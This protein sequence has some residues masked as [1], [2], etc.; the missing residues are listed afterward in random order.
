MEAGMKAVLVS[1]LATLCVGLVILFGFDALGWMR[2]SFGSSDSAAGG[3]L[4]TE[5]NAQ[6]MLVCD[7]Q[8][9]LPV[10]GLD[11]P[12]EQR[13]QTVVAGFDFEKQ[14]G[15]YGGLFALS[16][17]RK[18]TLVVEGRKLRVSR[19]ALFPRFGTM[20]IGEEFVVNRD[21]GDFTQ[22]LT[23]QDGRSANFVKG[24]CGRLIRPPF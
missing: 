5:S 12:A 10:N 13:Q 6:L 18:G 20:I 2:F 8:I 7:L 21:T 23:F 24:A 15:W 11:K 19:P 22:T 9:T 1:V 16:E 4:S 14:S 3:P 17:S